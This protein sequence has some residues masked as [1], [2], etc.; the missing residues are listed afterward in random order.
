VFPH[1]TGRTSVV[2]ATSGDVLV[3]LS[4]WRMPRRLVDDVCVWAGDRG[5]TV[6]DVDVARALRDDA[7]TA[8]SSFLKRDGCP[9]RVSL[10]SHLR[11]TSAAADVVVISFAGDTDALIAARVSPR[12]HDS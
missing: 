11:V 3:P 10:A 12:A 5:V 7:V 4:L 9:R 1:A 6:S 2:D 8:M